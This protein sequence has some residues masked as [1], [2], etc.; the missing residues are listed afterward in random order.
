VSV[1]SEEVRIEQYLSV[2]K[3]VEKRDSSQSTAED[4]A[5]RRPWKSRQMNTQE[6]LGTVAA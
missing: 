1:R 6:D 3:R 4:K 2:R 5:T